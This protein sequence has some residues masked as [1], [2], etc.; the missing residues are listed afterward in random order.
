MNASVTF[1][2][3]VVPGPPREV[4]RVLADGRH[5]EAGTG[6]GS[7]SGSVDSLEKLDCDRVSIEACRV[8]HLIAPAL[9]SNLRGQLRRASSSVVLNIA[10]GFGS[11]A[12][13]VKRRH[14]EIAR[15]STVERIAILDLGVAIGSE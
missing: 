10:E 3:A 5:L 14:Y 13:G 15:G 7:G 2:A 1:A 4:P 11:R 9:D 8:S 12:R 6:S